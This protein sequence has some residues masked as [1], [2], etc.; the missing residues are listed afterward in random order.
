MIRLDAA[1]ALADLSPGLD[2]LFALAG[3][4]V[5]ALDADYDDTQGSPV[6]TIEG[7]YTTR[8]STESTEG[9]RYGIAIL[10][11]DATRDDFLAIDGIGEATTARL[12]DYRD[13]IG[14]FRSFKELKNIPT[15]TPE[16]IDLLQRH[17]SV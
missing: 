15:L 13:D 2:R 10:H 5:A 14:P 6:F 3:K 7:K 1:P 8:G 17:F 4:K 16:K 12:I 9:F 11:N